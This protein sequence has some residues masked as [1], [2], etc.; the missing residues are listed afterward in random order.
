LL[1]NRNG[2][3]IWHP[4]NPE[5]KALSFSFS[6]DVIEKILKQKIIKKSARN[7]VILNNKGAFVSHFPS[8][9]NEKE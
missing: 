4:N 7:I 2:S 6:F 3:Y 5:F 8:T 1:S 9:A